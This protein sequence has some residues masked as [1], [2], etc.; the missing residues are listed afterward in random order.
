M[1]NDLEILISKLSMTGGS[2]FVSED[3]MFPLSFHMSNI[4]SFEFWRTIETLPEDQPFILLIQTKYNIKCKH[5]IIIWQ[6]NMQT[7]YYMIVPFSNWYV[8]LLYFCL[9]HL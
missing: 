8:C 7:Y 5:F 2:V 9:C 4:L 1:R 3:E 6:Y